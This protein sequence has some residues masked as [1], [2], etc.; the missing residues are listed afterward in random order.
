M[1]REALERIGYDNKALVPLSQ[2]SIVPADGRSQFGRTGASMA[3]EPYDRKPKPIEYLERSKR[4]NKES[5]RDFIS[6]SR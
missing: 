5:V 4:D 3:L 1:K 6:H 2:K